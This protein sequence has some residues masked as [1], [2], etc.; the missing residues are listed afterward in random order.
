MK[1][2]FITLLTALTIL[3]SIYV[4]AADDHQHE[5]NDNHKQHHVEGDQ[6]QHDDHVDHEEKSTD[7]HKGDHDHSDHADE[8]VNEKTQGVK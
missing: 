6:E 7:G 3:F 2:P 4:Y 1:N 8:N 5:D